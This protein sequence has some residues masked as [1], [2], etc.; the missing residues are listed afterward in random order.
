MS[1]CPIPSSLKVVSTTVAVAIALVS[2]PMIAS[3]DLKD[4]IAF[5]VPAQ[6]LPSALNRYSEQAGVQVT[7]PGQLIEGKQSSGINGRIGARTALDLLL[8][9]TQ[10]RFDVIDDKTVVIV[11]ATS[12]ASS[13]PNAHTSRAGRENPPLRIAQASQTGTPA[14]GER[15]GDERDA[16]GNPSL[17]GV[18]KQFGEA[19][20]AG[21]A[22]EEVVVFGRGEKQSLREIPQ[23]VTVFDTQLM[24]TVRAAEIQDMVR[25]VPSATTNVPDLSVAAESFFIRGFQASYTVNGMATAFDSTTL[26]LAN[27]ESIEVLMGPASVLYGSMEPGGVINVV[28]KTPRSDFH[29]GGSVELGSFERQRYAVDVGGPLSDRLRWR[30]NSAYSNED[31]FIDDWQQERVVVAPS[32]AYDITDATR[33]RVDALYMSAR[34]PNAAYDGRVPVQGTVRDNPF[35]DIPRS[36]SAMEPQFGGYTRSKKDVRAYLDHRFND[37]WSGNVS[38]VWSSLGYK[39][40]TYFITGVLPDLRTARRLVRFDDGPRSPGRFAHADIKGSVSTGP[41]EHKILIGADYLTDIYNG[42]ESQFF[43]D[44]IDLFAPVHG[45][46]VLPNPLP[47]RVYE[48]KLEASGGFLQD[49]VKIGERLDVIGGVRYSKVRNTNV[50]TSAPA[51]RD[52]LSSANWS[53]QFG[54][55]YAATQSLSVFVSRN[56]SFVPRP[57]TNASGTPFKPEKGIQYEL[58]TK[59]GWLDSRM[60][61]SFTLFNIEKPNVLAPDPFNLG[62]QVAIGSVRSRGAELSVAGMLLPGWSV[63]AAYAYLDAEVTRSTQASAEGAKLANAP[64]STV[65]LI[66]SYDLQSGPLRGLG[67]SASAQRMGQRYADAANILALP[68]Y[69]RVDVGAHYTLNDHVTLSA[70]VNNVTDEDI[71]TGFAPTVVGR[72]FERVYLAEI[73]VN[74]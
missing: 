39:G 7:S 32:I 68:N 69:T 61:G 56:E 64:S 72:Q 50:Q 60:T 13:A 47:V 15:L 40:P 14:N 67:F 2:R 31:S 8:K 66:T 33:L 26:E 22:L 20:K 17:E 52:V 70:N 62:F 4:T 38:V 46:T 42:R 37:A 43:I 54:A 9:D 74:L 41:L 63:H 18:R 19:G 58:G 16:S 73:K 34:W 48:R 29:L 53:S 51:S 55:V 11:P 1:G 21:M 35:G 28:T 45:L 71:Y 49:R 5:D 24:Q 12:A 30:V 65:S 57:G 6:Q 27:V 59:L 44:N 23:T 25:F 36:F 10:L 3:A